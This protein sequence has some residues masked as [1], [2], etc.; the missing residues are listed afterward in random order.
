MPAGDHRPRARTAAEAYEEIGHYAWYM[1]QLLTALL[2]KTFPD[3]QAFNPALY[4][5]MAETRD[6]AE[7]ISSRYRFQ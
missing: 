1:R 6:W 3:S 7:R 5:G 4:E 2:D